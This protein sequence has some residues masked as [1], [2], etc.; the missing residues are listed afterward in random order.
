MPAS[1]KALQ[2][3]LRITEHELSLI[4]AKLLGSL[5]EEE[6]SRMIETAAELQTKHLELRRLLGDGQPP[7]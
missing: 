6:M 2:K 7:T 1:Q 4:E 5:S 3:L